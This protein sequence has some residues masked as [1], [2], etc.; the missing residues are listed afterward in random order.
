MKYSKL[1]P[2][3]ILAAL[4]ASCAPKKS[5]PSSNNS[6]TGEGI[7]RADA[8][9]I[10]IKWSADQLLIKVP[11]P[12]RPYV[13][14]IIN[15]VKNLGVALFQASVSNAQQS[16][17]QEIQL[18]AYRK[19]QTKFEIDHA[20]NRI[21]GWQF[22]HYRNLIIGGLVALWAAIGT[23]SVILGVMGNWTWSL[24]LMRFIPWANPFSMIRKRL[25]GVDVSDAAKAMDARPA[26]SPTAN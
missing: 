25:T 11:A 6:L 23:A 2:I 21:T 14:S 7:A 22:R 24:R 17:D 18:D 4:A 13:E 1:L 20:A 3:V 19:L 15:D 5:P 10:S 26:A 8:S 9:L 16:I 12:L